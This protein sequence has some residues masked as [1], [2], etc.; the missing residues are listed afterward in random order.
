MDDLRYILGEPIKLE[1][2]DNLEL[3]PMNIIEYSRHKHLFGILNMGVNLILQQTETSKKIERKQIEENIKDFDIICMD[4]EKLQMFIQLLQISFK[5]KDDEI[6]LFQ[7][8]KGF[9]IIDIK[10]NKINRSN[11]NKIRNEIIKI[12]NIRL[13][14]VAKTK[15]LQEWFDADAQCS[16]KSD[17]DLQDI[18]TSIMVYCSYTPKQI[19]E[20][21]I[22]QINQLI[23]RINKIY[24]YESNIQFLCAGADSKNIKLNDGIMSHIDDGIEDRTVTAKDVISKYNGM[25]NK[26]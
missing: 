22:Y 14:K 6:K 24:E 12:N 5:T 23:A 8:D 16:S 11:Y 2:F 10:S 9:I 3:Y 1:N 13:P 21:T 15:E 4:I 18:I 26:K 19:S 25:I 17:I 20:M 7:D